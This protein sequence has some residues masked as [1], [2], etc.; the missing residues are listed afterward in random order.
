MKKIA[1]RDIQNTA[2]EK[3]D[4]IGSRVHIASNVLTGAPPP[5]PADAR[6]KRRHHFH[7]CPAMPDQ[8]DDI[9]FMPL[10]N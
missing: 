1:A 8:N 3:I 9:I 5:G 4:T 6:P 10:K 2:L 7:A